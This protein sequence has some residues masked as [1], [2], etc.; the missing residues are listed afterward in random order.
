VGFQERSPG[1]GAE[2]AVAWATLE[3][4]LIQVGELHLPYSPFPA[5]VTPE[6]AEPATIWSW[7]LNNI[8]DTN[9]P[10]QQAGEM[11]FHYAIG[12]TGGATARQWGTQLAAGLTDPFVTAVS[13]GTA[14]VNEALALVDDPEVFVSTVGRARDGVS[15]AVRL[16]SVAPDAR[17]VTVRLPA[18]DVRTARV[19]NSAELDAE[20]AAVRGDGS[21]VVR[22]PAE[23][24][25]VLLIAG[26]ARRDSAL[27]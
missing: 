18:F 14:P 7:A 4:P 15:F 21:I 6:P 16:R 12:A 26:D 20:P 9:F 1:D 17:E 24:M 11:T 3:A 25:R 8:W 10:S 2:L 22:M 23:A 13:R 5:T 19:A 27:G